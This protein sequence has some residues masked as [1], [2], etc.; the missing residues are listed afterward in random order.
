MALASK[1]TIELIMMESIFMMSVEA[2]VAKKVIRLYFR[3]LDLNPIGKLPQE[4]SKR[5]IPSQT[6]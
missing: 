3:R 1:L 5:T 6:R 4:K 2:A